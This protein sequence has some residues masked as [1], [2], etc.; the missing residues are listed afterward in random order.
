MRQHMHI[1]GNITRLATAF[2]YILDQNMADR[3]A[4]KSISRSACAKTSLQRSVYYCESA[5]FV[6]GAFVCIIYYYPPTMHI[7]INP[8]DSGVQVR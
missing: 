2:V 3:F 5:Y 1:D 6:R 4:F 7:E 8:Q